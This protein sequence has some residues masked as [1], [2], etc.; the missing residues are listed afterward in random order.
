MDNMD[1]NDLLKY[2][3]ER[4]N[5]VQIKK[6][7]DLNSLVYIPLGAIEWHGNHLPIGLDSLTS[8]GICLRAADKTKGLVIPPLYYGMTGSIWHHPYTILLEDDKVF[9]TILKTTL[10]RL[11]DTGIKK[12]ILF[13]G[14]FALRQ[15]EALN[16]LEKEWKSIM[17]T[18]KISILSI[19]DC[20]NIEMEADH[21]AIFETSVLSQLQPDLVQ[22]NN[23]P[24]KEE[25]PANDFNGNSK[26]DH[27]RDPNNVLFGV[28]GDDPRNYEEKKAKEIL[29]KIINWLISEAMNMKT[30]N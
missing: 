24:N 20:P 25:V 5:P 26:G 21:G 9:L 3:I 8:H 2:Q 1:N 27:R 12:V 28:F 10:K 11:E 13:T 14:H 17:K 19:S 16:L 29:Q 30:T 15:L 23:L 7:L 6:E 18:L 4:L 22:L